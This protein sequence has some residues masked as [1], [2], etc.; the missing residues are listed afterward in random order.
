M[1]KQA[2]V[3]VIS[4]IIF[5][6]GSLAACSSEG[7][8]ASKDSTEQETTSNHNEDQEQQNKEDESG[9]EKEHDTSSDLDQ[10]E[11]SASDSSQSANAQQLRD[12]LKMGEAAIKL[13]TS[14]PEQEDDAVKGDISTNKEQTYTVN[15]QNEDKAPLAEMSAT[16]YDN[17]DQSIAKI[18]KFRDGKQT[19]PREEASV[20][21]G[22]GINGYIEGAA[23]N[24][25]LSWE[26]GNWL[27]VIHSLNQDQLDQ[28]AIARQMVDYLEKYTLPAPDEKG[29][30]VVDYKQGGN[31][32]TVDIRWQEGANV[33]QLKTEQVPL[34]AL[35]MATSIE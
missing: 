13:P 14:F 23:G 24:L 4:A 16:Q 34:N 1:R 33:Y 3:A 22:H 17:S 7:K 6:C 5:F 12:Q 28:P 30:I 29:C 26:E 2:V 15:Y 18:E 11:S 31:D 27:I 21:L 32:V 8:D 9:N 10:P 20:D 35:Q 25:Y 19:K